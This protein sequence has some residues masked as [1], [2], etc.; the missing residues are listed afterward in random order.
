MSGID[1]Q[2]LTLDG[3][4][5]TGKGTVGQIIARR[6]GWN[7]LDSGAIY[8]VFALMADDLG[9]K[10]E[11][12]ES[13]ARL[14]RDLKIEFSQSETGETVHCNGRDLSNLIRNE[15][16]GEIASRYAA[17]PVVRE[18]VLELQRAQ[19]RL[20]GLVADG[21]DMGSTVFPQA[22]YKFWLDAS[23]EVRLQRR[24]K[25]LKEKGFGVSLAALRKEMEVRDAR[26]ASRQSSP[27][28]AAEDA[29]VVDT[30]ELDIDA[31]V[32]TILAH[33]GQVNPASL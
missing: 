2:V 31:V 23:A 22:S 21:R 29:I 1:A 7:Y 12:S 6:L 9:I 11:D 16:T 17:L 14:G 10:P 5:G 18:S 33:V 13:L 8:R 30:S 25:Q 20:P 32:E 26:D 24:Y 19:A 3:P 28:V 15:S 4:S 27:M